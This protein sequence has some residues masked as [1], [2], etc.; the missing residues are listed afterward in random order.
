[1]KYWIAPLLLCAGY[2]SAADFWQTKPFTA[3]SEKD[4]RKLL[5]NSPWAKAVTISTDLALPSNSEGPRRPSMQDN[6]SAMTVPDPREERGNAIHGL[7]A[8]D[9]PGRGAAPARF[10]VEWRTAL[11]VREA[12]VR[13][14][15]GSEGATSPSAKKILETEEQDYEIVVSGIA[16]AILSGNPEK[17]K[18]GILEHSALSVKGKEPIHPRDI[19]FR[20]ANAGAEAI[21]LF[22]KTNP[23][24]L[25]DKDK[26]FSTKLPSITIKQRFRLQDMVI[27][28]K[29]EL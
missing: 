2:L 9:D 7:D 26:E 10:I 8:G 15:Y 27:N 18:Q 29:L 16:S 17:L 25:E 20:P 4:A 1:M 22:P 24:T 23:L 21:F 12:L 6:P 3:W 5:E 19:Q 11:P 28:G 13:I 14:R